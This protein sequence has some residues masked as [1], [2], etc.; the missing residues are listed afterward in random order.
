MKGK[1]ST[2]LRDRNLAKIEL[3]CCDS[4]HRELSPSGREKAK[5]IGGAADKHTFRS[6]ITF[7]LIPN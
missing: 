5:R 4:G 2:L 1:D 6:H 3:L 7:F